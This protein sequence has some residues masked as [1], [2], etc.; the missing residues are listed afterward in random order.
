MVDKSFSSLVHRVVAVEF[1]TR[2]ACRLQIFAF[3][4]HPELGIVA[5]FTANEFLN[6]GIEVLEQVGILVVSLNDACLLHVGSKLGAKVFHDSNAW[7][8]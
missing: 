6:E 8:S 5:V 2:V 7:D 3:D 4:K 1:T